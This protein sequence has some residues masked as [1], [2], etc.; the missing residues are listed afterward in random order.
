ME[1]RLVVEA[2]IPDGVEPLWVAGSRFRAALA[3]R[4]YPLDGALFQPT[5][6]GRGGNKWES[7]VMS[8][9]RV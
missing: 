9:S 2:V 5:L 8:N 6:D 4:D 7:F 1:R 3:A